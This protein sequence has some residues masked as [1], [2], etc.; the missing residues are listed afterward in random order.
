RLGYAEQYNSAC[1]ALKIIP[2][3][4]VF[5]QLLEVAEEYAQQR[6]KRCA[7]PGSRGILEQQIEY[8]KYQLE[9][10][11]SRN[12]ELSAQ[13]NSTQAQNVTLKEQLALSKK[14]YKALSQQ[15]EGLNQ[16]L[17]SLQNMGL[18]ARDRKSTRLN[19]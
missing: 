2:S 11:Q 1:E 5:P 13:L 16:Q 15:N 7:H 4:E 14:Q 9:T 18:K 17:Y 8:F 10:I 6:Q 3:N 12:V 19:S